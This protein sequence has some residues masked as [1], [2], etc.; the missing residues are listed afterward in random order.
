MTIDKEQRTKWRREVLEASGGAFF[1]CAKIHFIS[2]LDALDEAEADCNRA[3]VALDREGVDV[4]VAEHNQLRALAK[5][6]AEALSRLQR[7]YESDFDGCDF[8]TPEWLSTVVNAA[9]TA[10]LLDEEGGE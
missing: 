2:L 4:L 9:R 6:L 3:I 10:G 7:L 5:Q 8:T 1:D